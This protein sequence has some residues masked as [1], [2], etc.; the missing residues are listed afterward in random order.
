M[1]QVRDLD[2]SMTQPERRLIVWRANATTG[3]DQVTS[4]TD[5]TLDLPLTTAGAYR[6]E[7]RMTPNHLLKHV[8]TRIVYAK[9]ERPWVMTSAFYVDP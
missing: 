2:A 3:W 9:T 6:V 4:T 7:V 1:P 5:P 8:G